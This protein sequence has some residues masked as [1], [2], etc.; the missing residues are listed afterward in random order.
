HRDLVHLD[1]A[2]DHL[3]DAARRATVM[4][5]VSQPVAACAIARDR[6]TPLTCRIVGTGDQEGRLRGMVQDAGLTDHVELVGALPQDQVR[7]EIRRAATMAAPCVV[8]RD[9]NADG[10]PTVI[11]EA[12]ALG[13]PVVSTPVTGIPEAVIDGH[14]G[15]L[16]GQHDATS[17]ADALLRLRD[18]AAQ[19]SRLAT[20][21]RALVESK[22]SSD[23]QASRLQELLP[24]ATALS[25]AVA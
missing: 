19:R 15:L 11:L 10:L 1:L 7:R 24:H 9:G 16:V 17:L 4:T 22:F 3:T 25:S 23:R 12:M 13:T 2:R 6:G 21:A 8:G 5:A 14:T 20:S 18:D